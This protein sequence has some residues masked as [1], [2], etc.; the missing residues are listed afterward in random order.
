MAGFDNALRAASLAIL[1]R[2]LTE[3]ERI[4]FL[5][6]AGA[7]GMETVQDYLYM[8]MIF[9]RNEDRVNGALS[10][11]RKEM[12]TRF[13]EIGSLEK[14]INDT[15]EKSIS[16]MLGEGAQKIGENMSGYIMDSAK[17]VLTST[18]EFHFLRG[19]MFV[20]C[21]TSVLASLAYRL[22]AGETLNWT[23]NMS[24]LEALFKLPAG[25]ILLICSAGYFFTWVLDYWRQVKKFTSWKVML[26]AQVLMLL[27]LWLTAL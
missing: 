3:E 17:E 9:K 8:L 7:I 5:D 19:Q 25:G 24:F 23:E 22:G 12:K 21:L 15:L 1:K 10:S 20:V 11:F 6:L 2:E 26:G 4:E 27:T 16:H 18:K 14:K 13:D